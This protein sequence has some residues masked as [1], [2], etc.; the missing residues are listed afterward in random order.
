MATKAHLEG[1]ARHLAKLDSILIRVSKD[2]TKE[3]YKSHAESAG[4]SLNAYIID[5]IEQDIQ[6]SSK[7]VQSPKTHL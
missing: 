5:L 4:K 7:T 1:N 3:K 6:N 2:G